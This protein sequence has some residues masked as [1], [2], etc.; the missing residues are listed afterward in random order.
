MDAAVWVSR[1]GRTS[2][3]VCHQLGQGGQ[4]CAYA[5]TV[6]VQLEATTARPVALDADFRS[7]LQ[8]CLHEE[9]TTQT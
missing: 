3:T 1:I 9:G 7:A 2:Y 4:R 6:I 5:E 8:L